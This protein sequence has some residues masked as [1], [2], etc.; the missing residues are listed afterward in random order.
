[1]LNQARSDLA[2]QEL[3]VESLNKCIGELQREQTLELEDAHHVFFESRREQLRLQE[4]LSMNEK[5]LR[6]TQTRNIHE[7]ESTNSLY[8]NWDKV[9]RQCKGSLHN[10]SLCKNRWILWVIHVNFKKWN[11]ITVWDCLTFPVNQQRF[12]VPCY[13]EYVWTTGKRFW[14]IFYNWLVPKSLSKNPSFNDT[15]WYRVG[16]SASWYKNS[17][18]KRWRTKQGHNSN[19][20][21]CEKAVDHKINE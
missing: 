20:D 12:Q 9:M 3:H 5:A 11:R 13:V 7:M 14:S 8:K 10:C 17:C 1:M 4:E 21:I 15:R 2:K 18:R 6:E 16:S 19:A